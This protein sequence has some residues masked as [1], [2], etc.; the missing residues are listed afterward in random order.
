MLTNTSDA[1]SV[2]ECLEAGA[3]EFV[4][5]SDSILDG[6]VQKVRMILG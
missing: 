1:V 5:K 2:R 4:V 3:L 6:V